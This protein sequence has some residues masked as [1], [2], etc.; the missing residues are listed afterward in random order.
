[1]PPSATT[2]AARRGPPRTAGRTACAAV[3]APARTASPR[4]PAGG[5]SGRGDRGSR[6]AGALVR[7]RPLGR[8]GDREER[9]LEGGRRLRGRGGSDLL[10]R[11]ER[12]R[13]PTVQ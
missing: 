7:R 3:A 8:V 2:R 4:S 9:L 10:E 12:D 5:G 13:P 1:A 11:A 6:R